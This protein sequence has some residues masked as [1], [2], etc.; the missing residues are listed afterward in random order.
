MKIRTIIKK[1]LFA[2]FLITCMILITPILIFIWIVMICH[3]R[4]RKEKPL[5]GD[6]RIISLL[7]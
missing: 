1:I 2:I 7:Y 4:I 3:D 5:N 6:D